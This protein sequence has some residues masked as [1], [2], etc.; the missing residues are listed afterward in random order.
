MT[1][2]GGLSQRQPPIVQQ[3]C[4]PKAF[5]MFRIRLAGS[6]RRI[7]KSRS[8]LLVLTSL[9]YSVAEVSTS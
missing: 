5:T 3:R 7:Q 2:A 4:A 8:T 1:L 6:A 9:I